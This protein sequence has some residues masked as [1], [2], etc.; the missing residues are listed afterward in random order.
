MYCQSDTAPLSFV[1]LFFRSLCGVQ[2]SKKSILYTVQ[3]SYRVFKCTFSLIRPVTC[4]GEGVS[5][6]TI[7]FCRHGNINFFYVSFCLRNYLFWGKTNH[8]FLSEEIYILNAK[9]T[10]VCQPNVFRTGKE[11]VRCQSQN[12][13]LAQTSFPRKLAKISENLTKQNSE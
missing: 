10:L 12:G 13:D 11:V 3:F 5:V 7:D 1:F 4:T 8:C 6:P 2:S 9:T